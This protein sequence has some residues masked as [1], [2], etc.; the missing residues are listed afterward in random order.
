M[1]FNYT[2]AIED[3][4]PEPGVPDGLKVDV[5]GNIFA[6]GIFFCFFVLYCFLICFVLGDCIY[7]SL[8]YMFRRSVVVYSINIYLRLYICVCSIVGPGGVIIFSEE[9]EILGKIKL[10][11]KASNVA[12]GTDGRLYITMSHSIARVRVNTKPVRI[13]SKIN[14][15]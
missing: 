9:G 2:A 6:T 4:E 14:R 8:V 5:F 7:A 15:K 3:A 12:F 10:H 1:L 11:E 13:L